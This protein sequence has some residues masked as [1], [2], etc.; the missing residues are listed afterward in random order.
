MTQPDLRRR[1]DLEA[2]R[3]GAGAHDELA[4]LLQILGLV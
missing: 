1:L 4:G 2:V 3:R